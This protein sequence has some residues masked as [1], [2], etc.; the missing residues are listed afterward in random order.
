MP[1]T[2]SQVFFVRHA[3]TILLAGIV[4]CVFIGYFAPLWVS[5]TLMAIFLITGGII[6]YGTYKRRRQKRR[7]HRPQD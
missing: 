2:K 6:Q 3:Y 1:L 4:A 5:Y 7:A